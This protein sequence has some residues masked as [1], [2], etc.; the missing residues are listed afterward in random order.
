MA[1][2][3]TW[4]K[5]FLA[6]LLLLVS[7]VV[8][9]SAVTLLVPQSTMAQD[10][11][12]STQ[13]NT[14]T[15]G[16]LSIAPNSSH[17][18]MVVGNPATGAGGVKCWGAN[19]LGQLGD[20]TTVDRSTPTDV[21]GLT[22][23][24]KSVS[25]GEFHTCAL[26]ASG[27][28]KC[29]GNNVL[30]QL[31]TGTHDNSSTPVDV[32]GLGS[33]VIGVLAAGN[34]NCALL[35]NVTAAESDITVGT[36]KCWGDNAYGQLG[37][38]TTVDRATPVDVVDLAGGVQALAGGELH[39]CALTADGAVKCWGSNEAGEVGDGTNIMRTTPTLVVG[40]DTKVKAITANGVRFTRWSPWAWGRHTCA[41]TTGGGVKCWG[42]N[43]F[44]QLGDGTTTL[45]NTP[46]DVA[47]L[48]S[49]V[50]AISAGMD[51]TCAVTT[52]GGIK[53]WGSNDDGQLGI[54]TATTSS[55]LPVDVA[56]L[57]AGARTIA[58]GWGYTCAILA[59]ARAMCWGGNAYNRL[60]G[61]D[62]TVQLFPTS[63]PG[64]GV[65]TQA[66]SAGEFHTC[67]VE[68]A[69]GGANGGAYCWGINTTNELG[70]NTAT[71][72]FVPAP[73]S[74]LGTNVQT[75]TA[76]RWRS[77]ATT[78]TGAAWCWG[79]EA[80][81]VPA[82]MVSLGSVRS[83][84]IGDMHACALTSSGGVKCWGANW[85]GQLGDGTTDDRSAPVDVVGLT[86]GVKAISG[87]SYSGCALTTNGGVK[88]WG[89]IAGRTQAEGQTA[90]ST[91]PVDIYGLTSGVQAIAG[92]Y[93]HTCALTTSGGVKCW[94]I[95]TFGQL[96]DGTTIDQGPSVDVIGLANGVQA[97]SVGYEHSCALMQGGDVMCWGANN[98]GQ[99]GNGSTADAPTPQRT[100]HLSG[101]AQAI[102]AGFAHTCAITNGSL[103]CWGDN[104]GGQ[105][106]FNPG[107]LPVQVL[108]YLRNLFLAQIYG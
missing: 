59:D 79:R 13:T 12:P 44:G 61:S 35:S 58:A 91:T 70:D 5:L 52:G 32:A 101:T 66:V 54:G 37:D 21:V 3:T 88:C 81:A 63:T 87:G 39:T 57:P 36:V 53:C 97:I 27:G 105:L 102:S 64:L 96:G 68:R 100:F 69:S 8:L 41:L 42:I 85:Y 33:G 106:G 62:P 78:A 75:I 1:C 93:Y 19:S 25:T 55:P 29:W 86:R 84:A 83:F 82:E 56:N 4:V 26:T 31:G 17:T 77:C 95:N 73:V 20:G 9:A 16:V 89:N 51:H 92:N 60:G 99:L 107:W 50:L 90:Y 28:V 30:G 72:R 49:G 23:A 46:V 14:A 22:S 98:R 47:G 24:V 15:S 38:G 104:T 40:I 11:D 2:A 7:A 34:H 48:R 103:K 94:G 108:F 76:G 43:T 65:T 45:H 71:S 6:R 80:G 74:G 18:C 67:V 10:I